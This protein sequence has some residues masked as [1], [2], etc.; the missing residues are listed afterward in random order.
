[1]SELT[2]SPI[3]YRVV[4][5]ERVRQELR[6]LLREARDLGQGQ[7]V[8]DAVKRIDYLLHIYP[9]FGQPLRDLKMEPAQVW[10]GV[11]PPL[12]VQYVLDEAKRLV[13]VVVPFRRLPQHF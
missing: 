5:S 11:I 3:P 13:M 10:I 12:S 6:Q 7:E 8:L 1:M 2:G 4:Y 9:Q